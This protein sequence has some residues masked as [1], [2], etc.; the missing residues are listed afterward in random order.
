M[1][2]HL[3][4][5]VRPALFLVFGLSVTVIACDSGP[6]GGS[7]E[8]TNN[9]FTLNNCTFSQDRLVDGG[10]GKD[11]IPALTNPSLVAPGDE[12]ARYLADTDRV[13]GL[14]FGE[15]A[16]AVP[17]NILWHHE[18]VNFDDWDGRSVAVTYCPLTGSSMAFDRR[19][20]DGAEFGVSGLLFENNLVMYDRR[21]NES[22]WPQMTRG[23]DCGGAVGADLQMLPVVEMTWGRWKSLHPN[24]KVISDQ[25][26]FS[27]NYTA[28]GYPYGGYEQPSNNRLFFPGTPIDDRRPPK[29]RVLGLPV[30]EKGGIAVPFGALEGE[31]SARVLR[32][33]VGGSA[34][35]VFWSSEARAAM[36][37]D[38]PST[39]SVEDGQIVDDETGSV[40][41]VEGRAIEGPRRGDQLE[42][43]TSAYVAFWFAWAVFQPET[44]LASIAS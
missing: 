32:V 36:A 29:E 13:I 31:A 26:G 18:I 11:G 22:L 27:R 44:G 15:S 7:S 38:T 35:T 37:Y 5:V 3:F 1:V 4:S 20:V 24:T 12:R 34:K 9:S 39:F 17:H 16:L 21:E 42:P 19:T 23:A 28:S 33:A 2:S 8:G 6:T 43:V 41:S 30:G 10:V 40:W 25:T 14:L